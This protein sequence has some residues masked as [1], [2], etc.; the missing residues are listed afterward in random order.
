[1][2]RFLKDWWVGHIQGVDKKYTPYL[3]LA[4]SHR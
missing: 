4:G 3:Q 1:M 2:L